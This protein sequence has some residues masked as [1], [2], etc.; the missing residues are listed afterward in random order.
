MTDTAKDS[1]GPRARIR[2][3]RGRVA[4]GALE[5]IP[6]FA[7]S[8]ASA[9]RAYLVARE[10]HGGPGHGDTR[11]SHPVAVATLLDSRGFD[12]TVVSAALLHDTVEDTP[13]GIEQ[14]ETHFGPDIAGLVARLTEDLR[15]ERY[16][17]RKAEAR[18]RAVGDPRAAAIYAADKLANTRR[19]LEGGECVDGERLDHYVKTL[20]LFSEQIPEL[21]FLADLSAELTRLIDRDAGRV[22]TSAP[23][24]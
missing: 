12:E 13:L 20:R 4:T 24:I 8:S 15:I 19:L 17:A 11:L 6:D 21:P 16:P 14:I 7:L 10:A 23:G 22:G 1:A 5:S 2:P 18:A 9:R 3:R